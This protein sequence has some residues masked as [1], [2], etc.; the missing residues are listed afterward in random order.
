[1]EPCG[2]KK[3]QNT[4]AFTVLS[5]GNQMFLMPVSISYPF[6]LCLYFGQSY[7]KVKFYIVVNCKIEMD[8]H[9]EFRETIVDKS[10]F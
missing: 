4:T 2:S 7:W 10:Y 1:M 9:M 3:I 8:W 5:F 6:F